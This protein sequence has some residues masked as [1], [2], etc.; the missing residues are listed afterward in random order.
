MDK[1]PTNTTSLLWH[2]ARSV[3]CKALS[4]RQIQEVR[5]TKGEH[6][7]PVRSYQPKT[8][9]SRSGRRIGKPISGPEKLI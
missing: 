4:L 9:I 2:N 8:Y 6:A 3:K 7:L 5:A 1:F